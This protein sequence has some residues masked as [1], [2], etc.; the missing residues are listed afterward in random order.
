M[1]TEGLIEL[2]NGQ[3]IFYDDPSHAY[4]RAKRMDQGEG[5]VFL[6]GKRLT[7]CSTLCKPLNSLRAGSSHWKRR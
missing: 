5:E 4:Y 2:P 1:R 3:A 7:S 6:R